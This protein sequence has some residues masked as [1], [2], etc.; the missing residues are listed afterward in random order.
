MVM[1]RTAWHLAALA[2]LGGASFAP[3]GWAQDPDIV[4]PPPTRAADA[5]EYNPLPD[6]PRPP[7]VPRSITAPLTAPLYE[8]IALP[9]CYFE[10]DPL[11]DPPGMPP[12]GWFADV[13]LFIAKAHVKNGLSNAN[14]SGGG[15]PDTVRLPSA[16]LDWTVAP[17]FEV[18]RTL[19]A[20]FGSI[21][22]SYRF[23]ASEGNG[24]VAGFDAP[25]ALKSRLDL[26]ILDLDYISR[27][28]T[29]WPKWDLTWR[30]G[31][32]TGWVY[33]DSRADEPL[34]AA[35]AGSGV[36]EERVS[37]SFVAF[38]PHGGVEVARR[39]NG[40]GLS[41][42]AKSDFWIDLGRIRQGFF[43]VTSATGPDGL[44]VTE[45]TRDSSSQ[46]LPVLDLAAGFRWQPPALRDCEFFLGYQYE[47][48]WNV[49][50][51]SVTPDS[52]GELNDQGIL[53]RAA[54]H[55]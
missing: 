30:F 37:N 22:L 52:R 39:F 53:L 14:I 7:D 27:E 36:F 38:G 23:L 50:R 11:L 19:P 48:W 12:P 32:R 20:G 24:V 6:L 49:G 40:T 46:D 44:P 25:A 43:E 4:L 35:A 21:G 26:N 55:F 17:R 41:L 5:P 51:L 2:I 33:F 3:K 42:V 54:F 29:P 28:Y 18:A 34:A 31:A 8:P 9:G 1:A 45:E 10:P 47:Y 15:A 13:D 16:P